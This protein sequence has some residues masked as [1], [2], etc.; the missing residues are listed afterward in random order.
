[1]TRRWTEEEMTTGKK[2][3]KETKKREKDSEEGARQ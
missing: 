3:E 1:V 2:G